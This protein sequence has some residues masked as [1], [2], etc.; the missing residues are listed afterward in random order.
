MKRS[1]QLQKQWSNVDTT[2]PFFLSTFSGKPYIFFFQERIGL[3]KCVIYF[4][5][6]TNTSNI[7]PE[8]PKV[9]KSK[10]LKPI[11]PNPGGL[12][13]AINGL[14]EAQLFTGSTSV[15]NLKVVQVPT[16]G[17]KKFY[18]IERNWFIGHDSES[19]W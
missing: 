9:H 12:N 15:H 13:K 4:S 17:K 5:L 3:N 10:V 14:E 8:K 11:L 7:S 6:K 18:F 16:S 1:I 19:R 2:F